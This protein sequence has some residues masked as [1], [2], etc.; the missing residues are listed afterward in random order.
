MRK[1]ASVAV[2]ASTAALCALAAPAAHAD[3]MKGDTR[4]TNLTVNGGKDVVVGAGDKS[5]KVSFK[6]TDRSGIYRQYGGVGLQLWR[7]TA[8]K[9]AQAAIRAD[10]KCSYTRT[11]ATCSATVKLGALYPLYKNELAGTWKVH[12]WAIGNDGDIWQKFSAKT[13]S[14]KRAASMSAAATPKPAKKGQDVTVSGS[15]KRVDWRNGQYSAYGHQNATLQ[16]RKKGAK[17]ITNVKT[18]KAAAN[19]SVK[20]NVKASA[21]GDYRW[22]VAGNV[23]TQAVT[24]GWIYVE[25]R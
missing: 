16:F 7:G 4:I 18:A 23:T 6:A 22:S 19:G 3:K 10:L 5:V 2:L 17:A 13:F 9:K 21:S 8:L 11:S 12:A 14:V 1:S 25:V 20:L 24:S 15:L